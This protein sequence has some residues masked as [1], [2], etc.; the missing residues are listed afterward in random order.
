MERPMKVQEGDF[1]SGFEKYSSG[2]RQRRSSASAIG[3]A[4]LA[5]AYK[6]FGYDRPFKTAEPQAA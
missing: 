6:E 4:T 3:S 2:A 1:A 5:R